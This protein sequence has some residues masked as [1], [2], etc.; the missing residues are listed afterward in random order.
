MKKEYYIQG[1]PARAEQ[2][3]A[4]FKAKGIDTTAINVGDEDFLYFSFNG[5]LYFGEF[6][7]TL[8]K[9]FKTHPD[10]KELELSVEPKLKV[11][12]WIVQNDNGTVSQI[13]KVINGTDEYGEYRAYDHTN[14]YFHEFFENEFHLWSIADAKDGDILSAKID[15][16]DYILIFKQI[17]DGWIETYGH[18]YITI[19]KFCAPTQMFYRDY[20]GT[21]YP[22]TQEQYKTLFKKMHDDGYEWDFDKKELKKIPVKPKFKVVDWIVRNSGSSDVPIQIY[23]LKKDRYLVTNMLGSKGELMINRQDE[24][25]L[26]TIE[27]VI[28][29]DV[30]VLNGK[31][32]IYS[33]NKYG[34]NYCYIDDCGQFRVNFNLVFEGNCVCPATKQERDL[35]FSKMREVGYEWDEK[36]KELRKI[37]ESSFKVGDWVATDYGK[38]SQVVSVDKDGDGYTLDDGVY[39]SGSWCDMYHLWTIQDVKDGDVLT[40]DKKIVI[41]S[42]FE[43]PSCKKRI[44]AYAGLDLSGKLQI[45]K[46]TKDSWQL[47]VDRIR[48]AAKKECDLLFAKLKDEFYEWDAC[49]KELQRSIKPKFKLHDIIMRGSNLYGMRTIMHVNNEKMTYGLSF[50]KDIPFSEQDLW[51]LVD[52]HYFINNFKPFQKVLVRQD[53]DC[54]W[55]CDL[56]SHKEKAWFFTTA[57]CYRQCIPFE[58]NEKLVG[59]T[60]PCAQEYVNW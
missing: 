45:T 51:H 47:S 27:D 49:K 24:W 37:I 39:F 15:G 12:D 10:Y 19:D 30:L 17:K 41:F 7:N 26:W 20:Q 16:D 57:S 56:Y 46:D 40:D 13:T 9:I 28:D 6:S 18:Y 44:M 60:K 48:P 59:T 36:K 23:N 22:A 5:L 4:A 35:L 42:K 29:G 34:K 38:V 58:G 54:P 53:D 3:K 52:S 8:L 43:E 1:N 14:G 33:H 32:F 21:L 31:P 55:R 50:G 25:H 11:G 2:I